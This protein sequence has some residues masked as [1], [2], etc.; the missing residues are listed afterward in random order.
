MD[1]L[2]LMNASGSLTTPASEK[3]NMHESAKGCEFNPIE[4]WPCCSKDLLVEKE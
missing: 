1:N 2:L 3:K 4:Y